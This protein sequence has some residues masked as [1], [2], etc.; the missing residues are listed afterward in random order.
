LDDQRGVADEF[1][2]L[3]YDVRGDFEGV[4]FT[5]EDQGFGGFEGSAHFRYVCLGLGITAG[6]GP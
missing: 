6:V 3:F 5:G 2:F 1:R 4:T